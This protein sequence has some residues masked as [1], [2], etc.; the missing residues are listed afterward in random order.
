M[1][2]GYNWKFGPFELIDKLGTEFFAKWCADNNMPVPAIIEKAAGRP[3]YEGDAALGLDGEYHGLAKPAGVLSLS[4]AT[5]GK[6][7]VKKNGS[8]QALGYR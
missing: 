6:T 8:C 7:P 5:R 2:W 3:L 4:D 1:R